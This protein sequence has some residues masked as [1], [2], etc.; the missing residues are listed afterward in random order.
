MTD[1]IQRLLW[2]CGIPCHAPG[3]G[4]KVKTKEDGTPIITNAGNVLLVSTGKPAVVQVGFHSLRHSF[5]SLCRAA[6]APLSVV[7]S[8]VGHSAPALTNHYTH[9]GTD[10]ARLA[11]DALPSLMEGVTPVSHALP[12]P[13]T[14][15]GA[16]D[17]RKPVPEWIRAAL[18]GI[19]ADLDAG[20]TETARREL[21]A[22]T[23]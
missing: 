1:A 20:K 21:A 10:A 4:M 18:S 14:A 5:V 2:N 8:I 15:D 6:N 17:E 23:A 7:Q 19:L 3:T 16:A 9:T 12:L 13:G 11:V 22:L